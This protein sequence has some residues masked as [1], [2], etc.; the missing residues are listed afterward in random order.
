MGAE[1]VQ[2]LSE[3]L[4][5][6]WHEAEEG[7]PAE[8]ALGVWLDLLADAR[9]V[10]ICERRAAINRSIEGVLADVI[11]QLAAEDDGDSSLGRSI[12]LVIR[13]AVQGDE[14]HL[15]LVDEDGQDWYEAL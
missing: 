13:A 5:A 8:E 9:D 6:A 4:R 3:R 10:L 11:L 15:P 12:G 2:R 14:L 1:D 7:T